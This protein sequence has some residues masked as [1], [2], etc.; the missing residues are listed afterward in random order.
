MNIESGMSKV[1]NESEYWRLRRKW[2]QGRQ[3]GKETRGARQ[4]ASFHLSLSHSIFHIISNVKLKVN[5]KSREWKRP[6]RKWVRVLQGRQQGEGIQ[7]RGSHQENH[8]RTRAFLLHTFPVDNIG[9][10]DR[11]CSFLVQMG[12]DY[13][14]SSKPE[15]RADTRTLAWRAWAWGRTSWRWRERQGS[16]APCK[17][18]RLPPASSVSSSSWGSVSEKI[19]LRAMSWWK[20]SILQL[21]LHQGQGQGLLVVDRLLMMALGKALIREFGEEGGE[22]GGVSKLRSIKRVAC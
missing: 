7:Q 9:Y 17:A 18:S 8:R 6:E 5:I 13:E 1:E 4:L 16:R 15:Q 14:K 2:V 20:V 11:C 3:Q 12:A 21:H 10:D 19:H 22:H